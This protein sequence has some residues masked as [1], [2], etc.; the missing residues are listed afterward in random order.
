MLIA[1]G[2]YGA[3]IQPHSLTKTAEVF[4]FPLGE[5]VMRGQKELEDKYFQPFEPIFDFVLSKIEEA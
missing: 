3:K 1:H 5:D 4:D 2:I